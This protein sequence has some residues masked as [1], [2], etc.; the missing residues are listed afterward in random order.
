[1]VTIESGLIK[2]MTLNVTNNNDTNVKAIVFH[3]VKS[4]HSDHL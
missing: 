3:Q 4:T 1:M 2:Q